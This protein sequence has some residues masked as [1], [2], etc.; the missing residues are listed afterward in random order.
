MV[1]PQTEKSDHCKIVTEVQQ[2]NTIN[3]KE[4][5]KQKW[6]NL[7]DCLKWNQNKTE[8]KVVYRKFYLDAKIRII[9]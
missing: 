7:P 2:K 6:K 5:D 4:N 3:N 1:L 8:E 9:V